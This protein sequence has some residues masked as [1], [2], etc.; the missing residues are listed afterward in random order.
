MRRP[1]LLAAGTLFLL[2]GCGDDDAAERAATATTAPAAASPSSPSSSPSTVTCEAGGGG[3]VEVRIV[4][5]A[6]TPTPQT[7]AAGGSVTFTNTDAFPHSV[8]SVDDDDAGDPA[9]QSV[10]NEPTARAP[11][12]LDTDVSSTCTF[13]AAPGTYEFI[14]GIHNTMHGRITVT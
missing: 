12:N 3:D 2:A 11:E 10:G 6:F 1:A 14:C 8:W 4:D 7:V 13:P 5:F 9:W